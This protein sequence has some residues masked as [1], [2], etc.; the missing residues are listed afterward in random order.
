M[1]HLKRI[2]QNSLQNR[3]DSVAAALYCKGKYLDS[4]TS[5]TENFNI[6]TN[7]LKNA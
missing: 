4:R 5:Y 2:L 7:I 6:S 3:G 1:L